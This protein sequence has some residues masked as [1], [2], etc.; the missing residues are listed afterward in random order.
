MRFTMRNTSAAIAIAL[1]AS[2]IA[3]QPATA[4]APGDIQVDVK[5]EGNSD[6]FLTPVWFGFHNGTFDF[7]DAGAT[8]S[9]SLEAIAEDG[10][11]GG[12]TADFTAA[13][14]IPGD[15]QGVVTGTDM[16][17]PPINPGETGTAFVTPANPAGYRYF[18]FAS[19]VIPSN[20]SFIGNDNPLAYE[21]FDAA[22]NLNANS[23]NSFTIQVF[24]SQIWDSGTEVNDEMGAAFSALGGTSS[25][26]GG[27]IALQGPTELDDFLGTDTAAGTTI[28]DLIGPNE[29]LATITISIVPEPASAS[30]IGLGLVGL[31][32]TVRRR[33]K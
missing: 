20:D 30:L 10:M 23:G 1:A 27:T 4:Q 32:G 14:G 16:A 7:F 31:C 22:G 29:L 15:I 3:V 8:A 13:P 24:G 2:L 28:N 26:E 33:R 17:P 12:L 6:F 25:D 21:V 9:S 19:M 11:T 5:N 18:S